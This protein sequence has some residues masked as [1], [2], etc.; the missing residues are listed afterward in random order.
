MKRKTYFMPIFGSPKRSKIAVISLITASLGAS[1]VSAQTILSV[2]DIQILGAT[3]D[4][5][6]SFSFVLWSDVSANT[7]IRFSDNSFTSSAGDTLL[8]G[9]ENN[10]SLTFGS[11]LNA[12]TVVRFVDAGGVTV[13]SG[14]A[15]TASGTLSGLAAAGDQVF[16]YQ[17]TSIVPANTSFTGTLLHGFNV[18]D[19]N[20]LSTG[21]AT[22]NA[23]YLPSALNGVNASFDSGNFDNADYTGARTGM[24]RAAFQ[25]AISNVANY[26]QSDTRFDLATGGFSTSSTVGLHWDANGTTAGDGGVGTWDTTTQSRFKN[27]AAGTTFLPWVN[28]TSGND[29]TA[30]FGG[31]AGTVTVAGGGVTASGLQFDTTG[32][33]VDGGAVTLLGTTPTVNTGSVSATITSTLSGTSGFTKLGSGPLTLGG[34]SNYTGATKVDVGSLIVNGSTASG[35]AVTV[36]SGATLG[37]SGTVGGA[38]VIQSG[39]TLAAGSGL[40]IQSFSSGL[41]LDSGSIFSWDLNSNS[42]G[43]RGTDFDGATVAGGLTVTSGTIFRVI[44]NS[45]V[46]FSNAFWTEN[47]AFTDI[48]S[49]TGG[50]T[51]AWNNTVVAVF[52]TSNEVQN[53]SALGAFTV[54]GTTLNWTAV[55]EPTNM[56]VGGLLGLAVMSRRRKQ[57]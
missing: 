9:N 47:R 56:L 1:A 43:T 25:A 32:Y 49:V 37:G 44:Q 6:D 27:A 16:A 36:A 34:N 31:T 38:T 4:G 23:S 12:G 13:S 17:G 26:T 48:F 39:G 8:S 54:T 28:S 50:T 20:W 5:P 14:T 52:N 22:N 40:G 57:A 2:G 24:T 42:I 15:P 10:M 53:V 45:G 33:T 19:T 41:T 35:S 7:V 18:A 46:D 30:V 55:P 3:S 51:S 29:H 11:A 21:T